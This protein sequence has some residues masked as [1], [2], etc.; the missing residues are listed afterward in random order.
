VV[1]ALSPAG[2]T[3]PTPSV[4]PPDVTFYN[5]VYN[6]ILGTWFKSADLPV[7]A[8]GLGHQVALGD[9]ELVVMRNWIESGNFY[10]QVDHYVLNGTAWNQT[11]S[12]LF[13]TVHDTSALAVLSD[14]HL[15][16]GHRSSDMFADSAGAVSVLRT[17]PWG[18]IEAGALAGTGGVA[19]QLAGTGP[20]TP[21]SSNFLQL[22]GALP[23]SAC[24]LVA[25]LGLLLHSPFKGGVFVP[26][27]DV[28]ILGLPVDGSGNNQVMITWWPSSVPAGTKVYVQQWVTDPMGPVGF[29][30]SNGVEMVGQ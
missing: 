30:A 20:L 9:D 15:V 24:H 10:P 12:V 14:G 23:N 25:G 13:P 17:S 16:V 4:S 27:P 21:D 1:I 28:L 22:S 8:D 6:R 19:P 18:L 3:S 5:Q 7:F 29:A 2:P 26:T 11:N